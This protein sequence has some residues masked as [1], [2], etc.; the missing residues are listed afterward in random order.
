MANVRKAN[1]DE[2]AGLVVGVGAEHLLLLG[3]D[4][5]VARDQRRL[6]VAA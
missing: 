3:R 6:R 2:H 4:G 1:L 5:G